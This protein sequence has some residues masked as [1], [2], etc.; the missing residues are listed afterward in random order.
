MTVP[1]DLLGLGEM[2]IYDQS[3]DPSILSA[4]NDM[5]VPV[6]ES[7][8]SGHNLS[9]YFK[10][11]IDNYENLP[12]KIG[13]IK[14]NIIGRHTDR[15]YLVRSIKKECFAPLYI[16][17]SIKTQVGTNEHFFP[18]FYSEI[19]NDWY[20]KSKPSKYF[21][22]YNSFIKFL[23]PDS[24]LNQNVLFTPGACFIIERS[25]VT[26][27]PKQFWVN[28]YELVT[29]DFFPLESYFVE[30]AML[31]IYLGGH[32]ASDAMCE[33]KVFEKKKLIF[34]K[35]YEDGLIRTKSKKLARLLSILGFWLVNLSKRIA[36]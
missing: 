11:F 18:G 15:D 28:L 9:D 34:R 10:F 12:E 7:L 23:F 5:K 1:S 31:S 27:Y 35:D 13:L 22:T 32:E 29:Y 30:R 2:V 16:D 24:R 3:E 4:L 14:G 26:Q 6:I 36:S 33:E 25:M 21:S 17:A 20:Q 19:N 8:H